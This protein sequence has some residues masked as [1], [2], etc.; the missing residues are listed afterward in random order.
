MYLTI[1]ETAAYLSVEE[2]KIRAF[3][4]Q[5]RIRSIYD[6]ETH[7]INKEQ[8]STHLEQVEQYRQMIQ[9]YLNEPLPE[10]DDVGDED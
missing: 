9:D 3:V 8:F 2:S 7:L 10:D 1:Q 6:G 5:G 4:L